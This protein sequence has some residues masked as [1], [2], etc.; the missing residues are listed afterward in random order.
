MAAFL[1]KLLS[2]D[3]ETLR[4]D[5]LK[6][7]V[8]NAKALQESAEIHLTNFG[9]ALPPSPELDDALFQIAASVG[10]FAR[11]LYSQARVAES[12]AARR[13]VLARI[14]RL[15]D[16]IGRTEAGGSRVAG[17]SPL[18]TQAEPAGPIGSEL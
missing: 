11:L 16:V 7:G 4:N 18:S 9:L 3:L 1:D 6:A 14:D 12:E 5:I 2:D 10:A 15:S 8:L 17:A 13:G